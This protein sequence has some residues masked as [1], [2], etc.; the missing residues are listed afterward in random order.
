M[1]TL[2]IVAALLILWAGSVAAHGLNVFAFVEDGAV[3]VEAK[4][5][6]GRVPTL[7]EVRVYDAT[8]A[9]IMTLT[10]SEDGTASFPLDPAMAEGGIRIEVETSDD[11]EDYWILT[12]ADI[13]RG[14]SAEG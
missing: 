4:F 14:T 11:H 5:S 13:A 6:S 12:P 8:D 1:S 2:R 9:L 3:M 10:L 7:G